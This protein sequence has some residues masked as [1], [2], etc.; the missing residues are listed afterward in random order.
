MY[1]MS[2]HESEVNWAPIEKDYPDVKI[3]TFSP[4]IISAMK[5]ANQ[6][7]LSETAEQNPEFKEIW[8]AQK[9]YMKKVR[10]WTAISDF[11]YLKDNLD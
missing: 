2:C 11:A 3:R 9:D 5:Q 10:K 6:E 1:A 8:E 4:E 7:L